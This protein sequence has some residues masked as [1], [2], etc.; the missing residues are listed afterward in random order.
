MSDATPLDIAH[1][2]M[3]AAPEDDVA[4]LRFYERLADSELFM[5]L[6]SEPDGERVEPEV[7]QTEQG[8]FV[9][10]FDREERLA[11]FAGRIVP[12]IALSGRII[13]QMLKGSEIGLGLNLEVENGSQM[14]V[15]AGALDWLRDTLDNAP[16]AVEANVE[17]VLPPKGL[18]ENLLI[19]LDTKLAMAAGLADGAY[20]VA[21]RYDTCGQGHLL[22]FV[23]AQSGAE[24]ALAK[25]VSEALIFS[26]VEAGALD[27]GF[28]KSS[29]EMAGR[30]ARVGLRY[31]L[32]TPVEPQLERPV[33]GSDPD[34]P[35]RLR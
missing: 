17:E 18:P 13:V 25:A 4:R 20:L 11:A 19:A 23:D 33:P 1:A 3:L 35:P 34:K 10:V 5:L 24:T 7:F 9:L 8:S 2:A 26:G 12:Y 27:V 28:F 32:P 21:L 16:E 29:D 22:G 15:P 6:A 14:L 31:E 30:L